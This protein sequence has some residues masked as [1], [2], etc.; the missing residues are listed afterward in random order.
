MK[1]N[2]TLT[3]SSISR[4]LSLIE[5]YTTL[6]ALPTIESTVEVND[7]IMTHCEQG[8]VFV[9]VVV[10]DE[11]QKFFFRYTL[12]KFSGWEIPGGYIKESDAGFESAAMRLVKEESG[13]EVDELSPLA[14]VVNRFESKGKTRVHKGMAFVAFVR[15]QTE[16]IIHYN[17]HLSGFMD[18]PT[19]K[20]IE[21][22]QKI[23]QHARLLLRHQIHN[24]PFTEIDEARTLGWRYA[25]H[26]YLVRPLQTVLSSRPLKKAITRSVQ[27]N[28]ILDVSCGDD[29]LI[30]NLAKSNPHIRCVANDIAWHSVKKLIKPVQGGNLI[31]TN[32][33]ANSLP[34]KSKFDSVIF[35]NS[36]HHF[37]REKAE[38]LLK[39]LHRLAKERLIVVDVEDPVTTKLTHR[40][41][42]SYYRIVLKDQGHDFWQY[43]QFQQ[44]LSGIF[45]EV[46]FERIITNRGAYM[47][48]V[49]SV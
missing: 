12:C 30:V 17:D 34:Y 5:Y 35:K 46:K 39:N 15:N 16:E 3:T 2:Q 7:E 40:L 44:L 20:V 18:V 22:D 14:K 49:C 6:Y 47:L 9:L 1:E 27:G 29:R 32:H 38:T 10:V 21:S 23:V 33:D 4:Y 19:T 37:S 25:L 11:E 24:P 42:N 13:L 36:L 8:G 31:F 28:S 43:N 26:R 41:W 45:K 48:A